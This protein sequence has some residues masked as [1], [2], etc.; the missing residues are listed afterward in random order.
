[1]GNIF[2]AVKTEQ[3]NV[4]L[5]RNRNGYIMIA[6]H[7]EAVSY[8]DFSLDLMA[9]AKA[10]A[11]ILENHGAQRVYWVMLSEETPHLHMHLFPRWDGDE[12]RG[13]ALFEARNTQPQPAWT[14]DLE[15]AL[16]A[17]SETWGVAVASA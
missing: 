2:T 10:W 4:A 1:M 7:E 8:S 11:S 13:I 15:D 17:W 5:T 14:P 16:K 12:L 9:A 3:P 6:T